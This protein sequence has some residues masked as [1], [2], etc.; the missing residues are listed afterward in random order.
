MNSLKQ[1]LINIDSKVNAVISELTFG[2]LVTPEIMEAVKEL[3]EVRADLSSALGA[4]V[5]EERTR[6]TW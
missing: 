2:G 3:R 5:R 6:D 4:I 1:R